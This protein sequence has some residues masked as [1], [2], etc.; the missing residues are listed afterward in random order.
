VTE[1]PPKRWDYNILKLGAEFS[2]KVRLK[3][4]YPSTYSIVWNAEFHGQH[5]PGQPAGDLKAAR[6][7]ILVGQPRP[8]L[9]RGAGGW[10]PMVAETQA[11]PGR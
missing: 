8:D 3:R 2:R 6:G 5:A 7:E 1:E 11:R 10:L 4:S 9:P